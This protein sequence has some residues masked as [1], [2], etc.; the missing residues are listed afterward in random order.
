MG[1]KHSGLG[2]LTEFLD[3]IWVGFQPISRAMHV[4]ELESWLWQW[5]L[6]YPSNSHATRTVFGGIL[7]LN[8]TLQIGDQKPFSEGTADIGSELEPEERFQVP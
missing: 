4:V 7:K 8:S 1:K 5:N 3:W 6:R 2:W